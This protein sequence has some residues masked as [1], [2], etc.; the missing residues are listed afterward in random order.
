MR[1]STLL[2]LV[3]CSGA[4][5]ET[6]DSADTGGEP[7]VCAALTS[8]TTS[9]AEPYASTST[10]PCPSGGTPD[11]LRLFATM[12][13]GNGP[14]VVCA[15][16]DLTA[17]VTVS[18]DCGVDVTYDGECGIE[19]YSVGNGTQGVGAIFEC[20][21]PSSTAADDV[22][23]P[24]GGEVT[25]DVPIQ[26]LSEGVWTAEFTVDGFDTPAVARFCVD[27]P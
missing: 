4:K 22:T 24:A 11:D 18:N 20:T 19:E 16:T 25:F 17:R 12:I 10:V 6:G 5:P 13:D 26:G 2:L 8:S 15:D 27:V 14:C 1:T 7:S 21:L 3:A 9:F 23:V